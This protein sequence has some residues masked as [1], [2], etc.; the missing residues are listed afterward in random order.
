MELVG[1]V[2]QAQTYG[3]WTRAR[4]EVNRRL[5]TV[6]GTFTVQE[7]GPVYRFQGAWDVHP[8]YGDQFKADLAM[9]HDPSPATMLLLLAEGVDGIGSVLAARMLEHFKAELKH[10]LDHEPQRLTEVDGI[11]PA[12]AQALAAQWE[13]AW[14]AQ[15]NLIWLL[16][17]GVAPALAQKLATKFSASVREV[18]QER[19]YSLIREAALSWDDIDALGKQ[20]GV[21]PTDMERQAA[22][23]YTAAH[24][25]AQRTGCTRFLPPVREVYRLLGVSQQELPEI[26]FREIRS[27]SHL[28]DE[29][30]LLQGAKEPM[31]LAEYFD[32]EHCIMDRIEVAFAA[33]L[34]VMSTSTL[35]GILAGLRLSEAQQD[36]V[37]VLTSERFAVLTGGPGTGKTTTVRALLA[38]FAHMGFRPVLAAPTGMAAKRLTEVT[39]VQAST[40]HRLLLQGGMRAPVIVIDEASM[41]DPRLLQAVLQQQ[42][43]ATRH[44][45][46]ILVGDEGQ[47][48]SVA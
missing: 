6:V 17:Q 46:V 2:R 28:K 29:F 40:I 38:V 36:A 12:R 21:A 26:A 33:S 30:P 43:E 23:L 11:G 32:A 27:T 35:R 1:T 14:N 24:A 20:M 47:L 15:S 19:P 10:V 34:E 13:A 44:G 41:L 45:R 22:A 42:D 48:P 5:V 18:V 16:E 4:V 31:A 3:D 39:G 37:R 7:N 8:K 25:E 9:L